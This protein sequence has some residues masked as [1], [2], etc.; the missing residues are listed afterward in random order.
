MAGHYWILGLASGLTQRLENWAGAGAR[1][2]HRGAKSNLET[3]ARRSIDGNA[4]DPIEG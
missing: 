3:S 4:N 2:I 1:W